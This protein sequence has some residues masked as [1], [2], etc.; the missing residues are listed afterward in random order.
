MELQQVTRVVPE[1]TSF[2]MALEK[3]KMQSNV[4][5]IY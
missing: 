3:I 4:R 1:V 5:W 2:N